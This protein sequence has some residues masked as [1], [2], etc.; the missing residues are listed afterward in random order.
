LFKPPFL[1]I[2]LNSTVNRADSVQINTVQHTIKP[3]ANVDSLI[4]SR[5]YQSLL[6]IRHKNG[7]GI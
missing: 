4:C 1:P 6:S 7:N 2:K 5:T 3:K